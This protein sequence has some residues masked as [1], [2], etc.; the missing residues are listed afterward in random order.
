MTT[1]ATAA[2]KLL[3][4]FPTLCDPRDGSPPGSTVLGILRART[5][6]WVAISFS[7]AWKWKV[8]GKSLS[9]VRLSAT[10]WTTAYQAPPSMGFS[11]QE[12]WSGVPLPSPRWLQSTSLMVSLRLHL[13]E[14]ITYLN[15]RWPTHRADPLLLDAE[16]LAQR[17]FVPLL[18]VHDTLHKTQ[19]T[20]FMLTLWALELV[21]N[22]WVSLLLHLMHRTKKVFRHIFT[23]FF[24]YVLWAMFENRDLNPTNRQLHVKTLQDKPRNKLPWQCNSHILGISSSIFFGIYKTLSRNYH[25]EPSNGRFVHCRA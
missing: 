23:I 3:Q 20:S 14:M 5:L 18:L 13:G 17:R 4:L 11:R 7:N 12:C 25:D 21:W 9:R 10:P 2:A 6:E 15:L 1:A 19:L 22:A 8:K 16:S 24:F